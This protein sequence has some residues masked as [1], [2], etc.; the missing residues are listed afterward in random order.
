MLKSKRSDI[1][2]FDWYDIVCKRK[3]SPHTWNAQ[4][5]HKTFRNLKGK[6]INVLL[7]SQFN[8]QTT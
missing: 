6:Y 7:V 3:K 2:I 1:S 5:K 8:A 4:C